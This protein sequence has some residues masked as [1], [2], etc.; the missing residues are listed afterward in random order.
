MVW[1]ICSNS[2][3]ASRLSTPTILSY[4]VVTAGPSMLAPTGASSSRLITRAASSARVSFSGRLRLNSSRTRQ[5]LRRP[6][7]PLSS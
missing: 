3:R 6:S 7:A 4:A 5:T 2:A 1:R